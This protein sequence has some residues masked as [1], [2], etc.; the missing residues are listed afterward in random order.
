MSRRA[1]SLQQ[2]GNQRYRMADHGNSVQGQRQGKYIIKNNLAQ[3]WNPCWGD[4][5]TVVRPFP[6]R[7]YDN[8]QA[9]TYE[10]QPYRY[11]QGNTDFGD[12]IR[13]YDA[14][15]SFGDP[16]V[17][18][19]ISDPA[20]PMALPPQQLP[21][22]ILYNAIDQAIK[23][24]Q[25]KPG[26]AML[27]QGGTGRGAVLSRP[28]ELYLIQ[29]AI[30]QHKTEQ[31]NPPKG[32][33]DDKPVVLELSSNAGNGMIAEMNILNDGVQAQ[34]GDWESLYLNGDP[35]SLDFGRYVTFYRLA[36][37]D[38]RQRQQRSQQSNWNTQH[39]PGGQGRQHD[40]IGFGC[41]MEKTFNGMEAHL[42]QHEQAI[43]NMVLP[44]DDILWFPTVDEQALI[45]SGS[46][47]PEMIVYAWRDHPDWI[48][49]TIKN[50]A[51]AQHAVNAPAGGWQQGW[52][53]PQPGPQGF[54]APPM[55]GLVPPSG[56]PAGFLPGAVPPGGPVT[57]GFN[58]SMPGVPPQGFGVPQQAIPQAAPQGVPQGFGA[59]QQ[60]PVQPQGFGMP[61]QSIPQAGPSQL[62]QQGFPQPQGFAPP[63]EVAVQPPG[64]APP[65]TG[66]A[67]QQQIPQQPNWQQP[68]HAQ[69]DQSLQ[70]QMAWAG[71]GNPVVPPGPAL[72][73]GAPTAGMMPPG[74]QLQPGMMPQ[75]QLPLQ[76][77]MP[78]TQMPGQAQMQQPNQ[79]PTQQHVNPMGQT[80]SGFATPPAG[81]G[82]QP[83]W[84]QQP[85]QQQ[86]GMMPQG[87][88]PQGQP[89]PG[90]PPSRAQAALQ[91]ARAAAGQ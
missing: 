40:P 16:G 73:S 29:C 20:D 76:T 36:D 57:P 18:M 61:Q 81:V 67:P 71:Q 55:G 78:Q 24:G 43:A 66:F 44:W 69:P 33:M 63:P 23:H 12:W 42:R 7:S 79:L 49:E 46:F 48:P 60:L 22:W 25:E 21:A 4:G 39:Q 38:P 1:P 82:G 2:R 53:Q 35:V 70:H 26:W 87:Q 77:Q 88:P 32:F 28:S 3:H 10:W 68:N 37:G 14:V 85:M 45:L 13:R 47:P 72:A 15:R 9:T 51:V 5:V 31:Y 56:Y 59:P 90:Q 65:T 50:R 86:P 84:Q 34:E 80:P 75:T 41:F 74:Q 64:F 11:S 52:T 54:S 6:A 91:A 19:I 8:P 83:Q 62:P 89:Q 30:M 27:M 17:T 58:P